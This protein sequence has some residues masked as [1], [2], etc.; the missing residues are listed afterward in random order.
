MAIMRTP[1]AR[2]RCRV[3][4]H[5]TGDMSMTDVQSDRER[6]RGLIQSRALT[7][8][9]FR[10]ASGMESEY[11]LDLRRVTLTADGARLCG[12]LVLDML[13]PGINAL[14]GPIIGADPIIGA[15]LAL[16]GDEGR[17]LAGFLVRKE[18]KGHGTR[19]RVEGPVVAGDVV[20]VIDDVVTTGGSVFDAADACEEA[21]L[22]VRQVICIVERPEGDARAHATARGYEFTP[23][24]TPTDLG[25]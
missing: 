12:R 9:R 24:F 5:E 20:A 11:Y 18:A 7:R 13:K 4:D 21:G 19:S 16:S 8:G 15:A 22:D 25:L 6:L 2:Y 10:L 3:R 14:G 17:T 1:A 23:V